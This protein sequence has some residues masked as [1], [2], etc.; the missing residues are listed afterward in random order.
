MFC[1][2]P[3]PFGVLWDLR[4][5]FPHPRVHSFGRGVDPACDRWWGI[6]HLEACDRS[7]QRKPQSTREIPAGS[8]LVHRPKQ[9]NFPDRGRTAH[10]WNIRLMRDGGTREE[11]MQVRPVH[12][13]NHRGAVRFCVAACQMST[14]PLR[15]HRSSECYLFIRAPSRRRPNA[16]QIF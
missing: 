8:S 6:I 14:V 3:R 12:P 15:S 4:R 1:A 9:S 16:F 13:L 10:M 7:E 5:Q 11:S 2:D